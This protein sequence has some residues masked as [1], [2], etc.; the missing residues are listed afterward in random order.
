MP[1]HSEF[2]YKWT[3][4]E[5]EGR[6]KSHDACSW[7]LTSWSP[8]NSVWF[9]A[10]SSCLEDMD[11]LTLLDEEEDWCM[12]TLDIW[13]W[14]GMWNLVGLNRVDLWTWHAHSQWVRHPSFE[15]TMGERVCVWDREN[16]RE[17][18]RER[19][20]MRQTHNGCVTPSFGL[21]MGFL[22]RT[23]VLLWWFT[24]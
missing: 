21:T 14:K 24:N 4:T 16:E 12:W 9:P 13:W 1:L 8:A 15:L 3:M 18:G 7:K 2:E 11:M 20:G 19:G 22:T 6:G 10:L 23:L 17:G 5:V